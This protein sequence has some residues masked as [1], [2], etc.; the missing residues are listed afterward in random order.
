MPLTFKAVTFDCG[1]ALTVANFWSAVLDRPLDTVPMPPSSFFASI[2]I[3]DPSRNGFMFI[4][5]PEGKTVKNRVHLDLDSDDVARDVARA[6][7]LGAT[8]VHDKSEYGMTWTTLADP[9]GNEF[10]IGSPHA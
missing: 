1:D 2:G 10:C 7:E 9:E 5:V 3:G 6:I 4:Q 8:H